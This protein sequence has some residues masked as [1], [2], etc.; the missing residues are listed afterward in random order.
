MLLCGQSLNL[1]GKTT[2]FLKSISQKDDIQDISSRTV[3]GE[4]TF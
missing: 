3:G 2:R 4:G 1:H